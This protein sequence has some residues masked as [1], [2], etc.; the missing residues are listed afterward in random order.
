MNSFYARQL[1]VALAKTAQELD[2]RPIEMKKRPKVKHSRSRSL[3]T[4]SQRNARR[5]RKLR[6]QADKH[7][8]L[9]KLA[10][11]I[12]EKKRHKQHLENAIRSIHQKLDDYAITLDR[13]M[14]AKQNSPGAHEKGQAASSD[15]NIPLTAKKALSKD[16]MVR[17]SSPDYKTSSDAEMKTRT[18]PAQELSLIKTQ[19]EYLDRKLEL[20][21]KSKSV[22]SKQYEV[23][24]QQIE[25]L[26]KL[27]KHKEQEFSLA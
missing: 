10:R 4:L 5:V 14:E 17:P 22:G 9:K 8:V 23:V 6:D 20:I 26:S 11:D 19:L 24:K 18:T 12:I 27:V 13:F 25:R 3:S 7:E 21:K 16:E 1:F 15:E 2:I